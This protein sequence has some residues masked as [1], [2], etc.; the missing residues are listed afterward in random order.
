MHE[1][2]LRFA[3]SEEEYVR[4]CAMFEWGPRTRVTDLTLG[5]SG[6]TSM[7]THG[8]VVRLRRSGGS[9]RMEF[10]ERRNGDWTS[11]TEH[12]TEIGDFSAAVQILT[13]IGLRPGLLLDRLRMTRVDRAVTYTLDDVRGLG[14]FL[15]IEVAAEDGAEGEAQQMIEHAR[16]GLDLATREP[17]RP[18]GELMLRAL[19]RDPEVRAQTDEAIQ[20]LLQLGQP[21]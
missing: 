11:W 12:G 8:W 16:C 20:E 6:A 13:G 10:K 18:Y 17:E 2:E 4:Y 3:L 15:E 9:I 1:V 19:D 14:R 7:Q 21:V 5:P